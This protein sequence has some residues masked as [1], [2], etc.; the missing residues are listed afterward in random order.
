MENPHHEEMVEIRVDGGGSKK[1]LD[2]EEKHI[3][4][5][6]HDEEEVI[7][8][9]VEGKGMEEKDMNY[10]A[11]RREFKQ[12]DIVKSIAQVNNKFT[13]DSA[14]NASFSYRFERQNRIM[15][16]WKL[17]KKGLPDSIYVRVHEERTDLMEA[18]IIGG[19]GTP[20]S[21]GLFFF[22][23]TFPSNYPKVPPRLHFQ[24]IYLYA[25]GC[26]CIDFLEYSFLKHRYDGWSIDIRQI[27]G[28]EKWNSKESS[29][30]EILVSI[31]LSFQIEKPYFRNHDMNDHS[32][33]EAIEKGYKFDESY[34]C[35]KRV[36]RAKCWTILDTLEKPPALF[37]EFI[38]QHF[39]E[40]AE[41][42]LIACR[43]Y[44]RLKYGDHP[45]YETKFSNGYRYSM[46]NMYAKLLKAFIK[47]GS[48]LDDYVGDINLEDDL[49]YYK[50]PLP[51]LPSR[52]PRQHWIFTAWNGCLGV[53]LVLLLGTLFSICVWFVVN[54]HPKNSKA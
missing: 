20:Y 1:E 7:Q 3:G 40:R 51:P 49:N 41:A 27:K 6:S 50:T 35:N 28:L 30:L 12:F 34:A 25:H 10:K 39:R 31:Q 32:L 22:H 5:R 15:Q 23:I 47:N 37:E 43:P 17:I 16:E 21:D 42:I 33:L 54:R 19:A 36:F 48:S 45:I 13:S 8:V 29:V 14:L 18:L 11:I 46:A 52:P 24:P 44:C 26:L 2:K 9:R 53:A 4:K 38:G